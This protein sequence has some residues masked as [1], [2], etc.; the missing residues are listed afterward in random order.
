MAGSKQG[1]RLITV[2]DTTY[3]WRIRRRSSYNQANAWRPLVFAVE[4]AGKRPGQP[5]LVS[6]PRPYPGSWFGGQATAIRPVLISA[7]IRRALEQGW[8]PDRP[9]KAFLLTVTM[10]ELP[11]L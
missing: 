10:D 4:A 9:G 11:A 3:R 5:L 8:R 6:L 2:G 7:C 1:A